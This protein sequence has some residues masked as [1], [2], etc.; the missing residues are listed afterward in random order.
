MA[1]PSNTPIIDMSQLL[2]VAG[3]KNEPPPAAAPATPYGDRTFMDLVLTDMPDRI[4]AG[5]AKL[6]A[7]DYKGGKED[8]DYVAKFTKD[9]EKDLWEFT[10]FKGSNFTGKAVAQGSYGLLSKKH[11]D[12]VDPA[13]GRSYYQLT[14]PKQ[15]PESVKHD[16]L[17]RGL[18]P[19]AAR[20]TEAA[21]FGT[22]PEA[23]EA[24]EV[25]RIG[26]QAP[27]MKPKQVRA[28]DGSVVALPPVNDSASLNDWTNYYEEN[29]AKL[30]ANLPASVLSQMS[31]SVKVRH[32]R[33]SF[34]AG[35]RETGG[36]VLSVA[37]KAVNDEKDMDD[38]G[39]ANLFES[40]LKTFSEG[41][42]AWGKM[43]DPMWAAKGARVIGELQSILPGRKLAE[44]G[45]QVAD[46]MKKTAERVSGFDIGDENVGILAR[47]AYKRAYRQNEP[48]AEDEKRFANVMNRAYALGLNLKAT[49]SLDAPLGKETGKPA[50][51]ADNGGFELFAGIGR[52][53][54]DAAAMASFAQ[55]GQTSVDDEL[56]YQVPAIE[57]DLKAIG[58][59]DSDAARNG[60][61]LFAQMLSSGQEIDFAK[62]PEVLAQQPD[63]REF[64][65]EANKKAVAEAES[66]GLPTPPALGDA[67]AQDAYARAARTIPETDP[68]GK[69]VDPAEREK[70]IK[71]RANE[72][73]AFN[74]M[75]AVEKIAPADLVFSLKAGAGD[76]I[77]TQRAFTDTIAPAVSSVLFEQSPMFKYLHSQ[78]PL[79]DLRR[80]ETKDA[81]VKL[82]MDAYGS[83]VGL[84]KEASSSE[85][86]QKVISAQVSN[87][88]DNLEQEARRNGAAGQRAPLSTIAGTGTAES[89]RDLA[90]S[91][92]LS[93]PET[94]AVVTDPFGGPAAVGETLT[95]ASVAQ[96]L[97]EA[98]FADIKVPEGQRGFAAAVKTKLWN[99][100]SMPAPA[101]PAPEAA[102]A[103]VAPSFVDVSRF[104]GG[105]AGVKAGYEALKLASKKV[106]EPIRNAAVRRLVEDK[107]PRLM[108]GLPRSSYLRGTMAARTMATSGAS[109][110]DVLSAF[111][112]SFS[113]EERRIVEANRADKLETLRA[114]KEIQVAAAAA[115]AAGQ[116]M[117]PGTVDEA[118]PG[119]K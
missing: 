55:G 42:K 34:E 23:A 71:E 115:A 27:A 112:D 82:A 25:L 117:V 6:A 108:E 39:K 93:S 87:I 53:A 16:A 13:S 5:Q 14:D 32:L 41:R 95:E 106:G 2:K 47:T 75:Q 74:F 78:V 9:Y 114:T 116:S 37:T 29:S 101:A 109:V 98:F 51:E 65:G 72:D 100:S 30:A 103:P 60:A 15:N 22:G 62:L 97:G 81:A 59:S 70:K 64:V 35:D 44:S 77:A 113:A 88:I 19:S 105:T 45:A 46:I 20:F 96:D 49:P 76:K 118:A 85:A 66:K 54:I 68:T 40:T 58:V 91:R 107:L 36:A 10:N 3:V 21:R 119:T 8:F 99:L 73:P 79:S 92:R 12:E 67:V 18:A 17:L 111:M 28:P 84:I 4:R 52:Q 7:G 63:L 38:L 80:A 89:L 24:A 83:R 104:D 11:L 26:E 31:P 50:G 94:A 33:T 61:I 43:D 56:K 102:P 57:Q 48:L 90:R 110:D 86:L 69:P 1:Y